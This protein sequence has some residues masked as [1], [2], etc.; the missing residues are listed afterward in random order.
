MALLFF[1]SDLLYVDLLSELS[2]YL[3]LN[4]NPILP[5]QLSGTPPYTGANQVA[6]L[7][8]IREREARLPP[9]VATELSAACRALVHALL[10]RNA[11]ER[12]SFE[13]FF[14]HPFVTGSPMPTFTD[15]S[16]GATTSFLTSF[17]ESRGVSGPQ[18]QHIV[19]FTGGDLEANAAG[20]FPPRAAV[21]VSQL[22]EQFKPRLVSIRH[23]VQQH[24]QIKP[25]PPLSSPNHRSNK[26]QTQ[27]QQLEDNTAS[28]SSVDDEEYVIVTA[29]TAEAAAA[30]AATVSPAQGAGD[31]HH[32][33]PGKTPPPQEG[34]LPRSAG[35]TRGVGNISP[36]EAFL[37][38]PCEG[39]GRGGTTAGAAGEA[40]SG[41]SGDGPMGPIPDAVPWQE[42]SRRQF[43]QLVAGILDSL[44]CEAGALA[45]TAAAIY[46]KNKEERKRREVAMALASQLSFQ[47]AALQLHEVVLSGWGRKSASSEDTPQHAQ[48]QNTQHSMHSSLGSADSGPEDIE[49]VRIEAA[50]VLRRADAAAVAL[51]EFKDR[52]GLSS[53]N[54]NNSPTSIIASLDLPNP[55]QASHKAALRWAEEAASEELL[56]NYARSEALYCRAGMVLHFLAAEAR[57]LPCKPSPQ[58]AAADEIRLRRCAS[59]AAVRW[60]VCSALAKRETA[61][62]EG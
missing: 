46:Q 3:I 6:L 44:G 23:P 21:P 38:H 24:R 25:T 59:A 43:L 60:A 27:A 22:T 58:V 53:E 13:E 28:I 18:K 2:F 7:R 31:F 51:Q 15:G 10:R 40:S 16:S 17:K 50:A 48:Q 52:D 4:L 41:V 14:N 49:Q 39:G 20:A 19:G 37:L 45:A 8:S 62:G 30:A 33:R 34:M 26:P 47:L 56:G 32:P 55:W 42:T 61:V 35:N 9:A 12:I 57:S 54:N 5:L 1:E 29:S 36:R 11:V